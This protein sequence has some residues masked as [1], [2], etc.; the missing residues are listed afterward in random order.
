MKDEEGGEKP[1]LL[2]AQVRF[3]GDYEVAQAKEV[4]EHQTNLDSICSEL[5]LEANR[6]YLRE[7]RTEVDKLF[8]DI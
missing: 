6:R 5:E 7:A 4:A 1:S 2:V 3:E 8:M